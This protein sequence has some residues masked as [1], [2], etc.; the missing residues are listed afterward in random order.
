MKLSEL[1]RLELK[2]LK[3]LDYKGVLDTV[4]KRND[5]LIN[6]VILGAALMLTINSLNKSGK[7]IKMIKAEI[8]SWEEKISA[9][10]NHD[11]LK[12]DMEKYQSQAPKGVS[13]DQMVDLL[14]DLAVNRNIQILSVSP[15]ETSKKNLHSLTNTSMTITAD[16]YADLWRFIYD[17]EHGPG[18]L[19]IS[20]ME[21]TA[22]DRKASR[23][24]GEE[25]RKQSPFKFQVRMD[26]T[27]VNIETD[28]E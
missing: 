4:R 1:S 12:Q 20:R 22:E 6:V 16:S 18:T 28:N 10:T 9:V 3:K 14:T 25:D 13:G 23:R 5:V 15:A 24:S 17:I 7:Q 21:G 26:V 2:D 19:R 8:A 27:S 11:R